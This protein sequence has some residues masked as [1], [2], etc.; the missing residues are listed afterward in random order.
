MN[1]LH[2]V[3]IRIMILLLSGCM[4]KFCLSEFEESRDKEMGFQLDRREGRIKFELIPIIILKILQCL[5]LYL[6]V[7]HPTIKLRKKGDQE[8]KINK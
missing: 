4:Q 7:W 3:C 8:N 2:C 6:V 5:V 1:Y